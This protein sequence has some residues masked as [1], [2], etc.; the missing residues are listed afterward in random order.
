M[1]CSREEFG[2]AEINT[3]MKTHLRHIKIESNRN[4]RCVR[5]NSFM[6]F[7]DNRIRL[8]AIIVTHIV[9]TVHTAIHS[10]EI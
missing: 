6:V 9:S 5:V 8:H 3:E 4:P 2:D 1:I 10:E 7:G